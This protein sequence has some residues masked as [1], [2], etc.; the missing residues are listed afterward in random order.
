[1]YQS[2]LVYHAWPGVEALS[3][4]RGVDFPPHSSSPFHRTQ[5]L[6][7]GIV[8]SGEC[9]LELDNGEQRLM[10]SG[11]CCRSTR[12]RGFVCLCP[13]MHLES[14]S[15]S[16]F[17]TIHAWVNKSDT[18]CRMFFVLMA[19]KE[20][21]IN[22]K[23]LGFEGYEVCALFYF[24]LSREFGQFWSSCSSLADTLESM[25]TFRGMMMLVVFF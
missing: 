25:M 4:S 15:A 18:P 5:S 24:L 13:P 2:S 19:A 23:K 20:L 14:Y 12:V 10:K 22:G 8:H 21:A 9:Y 16:A 17:S 6:D 7:L 1:M 3:H 11:R